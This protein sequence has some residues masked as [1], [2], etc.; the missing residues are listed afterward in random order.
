[1]AKNERNNQID[2]TAAGDGMISVPAGEDG[3]D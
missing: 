1:M 2:E 3:W